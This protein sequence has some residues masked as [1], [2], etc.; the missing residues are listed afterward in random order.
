MLSQ[1]ILCGIKRIGLHVG[2]QEPV[3]LL[4]TIGICSNQFWQIMIKKAT[5]KPRCKPIPCNEYRVPVMRTGVPCNESRFFPVRI[6]YTGKTLFWPCTGPVW[7]CSVVQFFP[8]PKNSTKR[9]PPVAYTAIPHRVST[10]P[11]K[12][13]PCVVNSHREKPAIITKNP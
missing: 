1:L 12:G 10:G 2:N 6:Y 5:Y 3:E 4:G 9:G 7:D 8:G 11:E 13:F